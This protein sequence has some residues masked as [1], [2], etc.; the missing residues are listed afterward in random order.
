MQKQK[1]RKKGITVKELLTIIPDDVLRT[2]A[3]STDVDKYTKILYGR[4]MFYMILYS[5]LETDRAS[6]RTMEDVFNSAKFKFLFN[7]DQSKTVRYNSIS[8][9][10]SAINVDFF[11]KAFGYF[12][13]HISRLYSE[14]E[15]VNLNIIRVDSTMVAETSAKLKKGM[16]FNHKNN[17]KK[18]VKFTVA[19]DGMFPCSVQTFFDQKELNECLTIPEVVKAHA[20]KHKL[21]LYV[22]DRGVNKRS[23]FDDLHAE[24]IA[25][26]T[27][28]NANASYTSVKILENEQRCIGSLKLIRDEIVHLHTWVNN[29]KTKKPT[30]ETFRL[31]TAE[32]KKGE[33]IMFLT[34]LKDETVE[35][36]LAFYKQRWDIEVFFRFIKQELNFSHFMSTNENGIKVILYMT[37]ILSMLILIYKRLN[38]LGFKT[39]KRRFGIELDEL[40]IALI[41]RFCG[42]DPSL[43]FR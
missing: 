17:S 30:K 37:L 18:Q 42:G 36:I 31:I 5:L 14:Q 33:T 22:F 28:L 24:S 39:S 1:S 41:V 4:S 27:R 3:A 25:F 6:L 43:V 9:R 38:N 40:I 8:E 20:K 26:V 23:I 35:N 13:N 2:L 21:K 11:E 16:S 34:N 19:F 10:L 29:R 7:L 32:T 15:L 12:Y